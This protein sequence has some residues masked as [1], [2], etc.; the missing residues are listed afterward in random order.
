V[1][2]ASVMCRAMKLKLYS[3]LGYRLEGE[4]RH[5]PVPFSGTRYLT[6]LLFS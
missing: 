3:P 2:R 5:K 4:H 6:L 1:S